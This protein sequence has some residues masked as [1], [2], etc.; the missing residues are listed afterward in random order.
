MTSRGFSLV[1]REHGGDSRRVEGIDAD[2]FRRQ[3]SNESG[4]VRLEHFLASG[5]LAGCLACG[6][7]ELYTKKDFPRALGFSV[8][9]LAAFLAPLTHYLSL[10]AAAL[11]D[12]FLFRCAR[13]VVTCYVCRA[14]HRG[15][16]GRPRHPAFDREIDE[17]L[18]Y[19]DRAVMGRPMRA[20]GT[21]GAPEPDH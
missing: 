1:I 7:L 3:G 11:L 6:H 2:E 12:M 17:R 15:F 19:G 14:E 21:A 9:A 13:D 20:G 18:R 8:V 5:G 10:V 4:R 16:A